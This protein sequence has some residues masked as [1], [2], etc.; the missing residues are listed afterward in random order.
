MFIAKRKL[1]DSFIKVSSTPSSVRRVDGGYEFKFSYTVDHALLQNNLPL[2]ASVHVG[3]TIADVESYLAKISLG[4]PSLSSADIPSPPKLVLATKD[5]GATTSPQK[6]QLPQRSPLKIPPRPPA[7]HRPPLAQLNTKIEVAQSAGAGIDYADLLQ[8]KINNP[9]VQ[10]P[11]GLVLTAVAPA[12]QEVA[13]VTDEF[14]F[15]LPSDVEL[16]G[17]FFTFAVL[18]SSGVP[19]QIQQV[20]FSKE[21]LAEFFRNSISPPEVSYQ[22]LRGDGYGFANL[23]QVD[24]SANRV[25]VFRK[26]QSMDKAL[27][28][29]FSLV[30]DLPL[31]AGKETRLRIDSHF[32]SHVIYRFLACDNFGNIS[33]DF[34]SVVVD[35]DRPNKTHST[36]SLYCAEA[37][38]GTNVFIENIPSTAVSCTLYAQEGQARLSGDFRLVGSEYILGLTR[39][40]FLDPSSKDGL[41]RSYKLVIQHQNGLSTTHFSDTEKCVRKKVGVGAIKVEN[42]Q[43][44][45]DTVSFSLSTELEKNQS[46]ILRQLLKSNGYDELF[47]QESINEREKLNKVISHKVFRIDTFSGD[48]V[49]FGLVA[50]NFD[51]V[52]RSELVGAPPVRSEGG[53]KY[54]IFSCVRSPETLFSDYVKTSKDTGTGRNYQWKPSISLSPLALKG[55]VKASAKSR[56]RL[57]S[58]SEIDAAAIGVVADIDVTIPKASA[59][60]TGATQTEISKTQ[61]LLKLTILDGSLGVDHYQILENTADGITSVGRLFPVS[62]QNSYTI[63]VKKKSND[64]DFYISAVTDSGIGENIRFEKK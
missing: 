49:D 16:T 56:Q 24:M 53:Y 54:Q 50:D 34:S 28:A 1:K 64:S 30:R 42:L 51:D 8:R 22:A 33:S 44:S 2:Q 9:K 46:E 47:I 27:R 41:Y 4:K 11:A 57:T 39:R 6:A 62:G 10:N 20:Q 58:Y 38:D 26:V 45:S 31:A 43:V 37:V 36:A 59:R 19:V 35:A 17:G 5:L 60:L 3:K 55:G 15:V 18:N 14:T 32:G 61:A 48:V 21:D 7:V 29:E 12:E 25:L 52:E 13:Y 23:K 63:T 40:F